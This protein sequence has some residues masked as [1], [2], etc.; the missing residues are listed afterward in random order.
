[1]GIERGDGMWDFPTVVPGGT[2]FRSNVKS[3]TESV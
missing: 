1:M 3:Q 2:Y